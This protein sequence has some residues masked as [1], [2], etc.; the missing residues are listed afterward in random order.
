MTGVNGVNGINAG[1]ANFNNGVNAVVSKPVNNTPPQKPAENPDKKMS[2]GMKVGLGAA[3]VAV[4]VIAGLAIKNKAAVKAAEKAAKKL[5]IDAKSY[6][7]LTQKFGKISK[8]ETFSNDVLSEHVGKLVSEVGK[9]NNI[10]L[11]HGS[12]LKKQHPEIPENAIVYALCKDDKILSQE[13]IMYDSI[14]YEKMSHKMKSFLT[15]KNDSDVLVKP[16]K[17]DNGHF[18]FDD[19][20]YVE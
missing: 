1:G 3:A 16:I 6:L 15:N 20:F 10:K 13:V 7:S 9:G 12:A 19:T 18:N 17:I 5:G 14:D 2:T 4:S 8:E 11:V